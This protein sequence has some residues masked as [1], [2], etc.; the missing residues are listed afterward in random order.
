MAKCQGIENKRLGRAADATCR[1]GATAA[2]TG[3]V[4]GGRLEKKLRSE[5]G[6]E[7]E[8]GVRGGMRVRV[9]IWI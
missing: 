1:T 8:G 6:S 7:E 5:M 9:R 2:D 3:R 4:Q